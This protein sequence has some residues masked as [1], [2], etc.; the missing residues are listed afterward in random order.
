ML[1]WKYIIN[2]LTQ[3]C[4]KHFIES[5][6]EDEVIRQLAVDKGD[7]KENVSNGSEILEPSLDALVETLVEIVTDLPLQ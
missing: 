2:F 5:L 3:V 6:K 7:N 1:N 4:L